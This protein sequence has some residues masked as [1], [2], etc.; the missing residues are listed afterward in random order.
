M[1]KDFWKRI[2]E[3]EELAKMASEGEW[4]IKTD[5][6]IDWGDLLITTE[7]QRRMI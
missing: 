3:L 6:M 1:N 5:D 2:N 7:E 4:I